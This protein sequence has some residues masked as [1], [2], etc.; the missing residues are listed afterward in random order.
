MALHQII[1]QILGIFPEPEFPIMIYDDQRNDSGSGEFQIW[2][3]IFKYEGC[4]VCGILCVYQCMSHHETKS[5]GIHI[6]T[7]VRFNVM[8]KFT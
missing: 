3:Q 4:D 8:P 6:T 1:A 2:G 5:S 7:N